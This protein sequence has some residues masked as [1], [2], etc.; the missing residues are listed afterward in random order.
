M[1]EDQARSGVEPG[2]AARRPGP[3][4]TIGG[5]LRLLAWGVAASLAGGVLLSIVRGLI[6]PRRSSALILSAPSCLALALALGL[7]LGLTMR[8]LVRRAG[9]RRAGLAFSLSFYLGALAFGL[10]YYLDYLSMRSECRRDQAASVRLRE[11]ADSPGRGDPLEW[12]VGVEEHLDG[13]FTRAGR[14]EDPESS[15]NPPAFYGYI[16]WLSSRYAER[17]GLLL[18]SFPRFFDRRR[19]LAWLIVLAAGLTLAAFTAGT[20]ARRGLGRPRRCGECGRVLAEEP[21]RIGRGMM[22]GLAAA[23]PSLREFL[24]PGERPAERELIIE[25]CGGPSTVRQAH[26]PE[27]SRRAGSGPPRAK[28]RG[29]CAD[30]VF[31]TVRDPLRLPGRRTLLRAQRLSPE[32]FDDLRAELGRAGVGGNPPLVCRKRRT[33]V[34][35]AGE[36]TLLHLAVLLL[37]AA[38]LLPLAERAGLLPEP[39][40]ASWGYR[41]LLAGL[42][43]LATGLAWAWIWRTLYK[44]AW[45]RARAR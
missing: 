14:V 32:E 12:V 41:T 27:H 5:L 43:F 31:I 15:R 35:H 39:F 10:S 11:E 44:R 45:W 34:L 40:G 18:R 8:P 37:A 3:A 38:A 30:A 33:E 2:P 22:T 21:V 25:R 17:P 42:V 1:A 9:C 7:A 29:G 26:G 19:R 4:C 13:I 6:D 28:S 36:R 24:L 23:L 20:T 16:G